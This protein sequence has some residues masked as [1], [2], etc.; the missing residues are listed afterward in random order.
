MKKQILTALAAAVMI[1]TAAPGQAQDRHVD[2][3][4]DR[5]GKTIVSLKCEGNDCRLVFDEHKGKQ[6]WGHHAKPRKHRVYGQHWR[7]KQAR[8]RRQARK[9]L[10]H[11]R[12]H[13]RRHGHRHDRDHGQRHDRHDDRHQDRHQDRVERRHHDRHG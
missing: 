6:H 8:E 11:D 3:H 12:H 1:F 10:R 9:S 4:E 7:K 5:H 2:R 13:N